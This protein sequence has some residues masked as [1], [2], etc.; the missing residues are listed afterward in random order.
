MSTFPRRRAH[1]RVIKV[2]CV[3]FYKANGIWKSKKSLRGGETVQQWQCRTGVWTPC[4][5]V[6]SQQRSYWLQRGRRQE[7]DSGL[8]VCSLAKKMQLQTQRL[9]T[10]KKGWKMTGEFTTGLLWLPCT[11]SCS[12]TQILKKKKHKKERTIHVWYIVSN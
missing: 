8:L 2:M 6:V 7:D 1:K 11:H 12:H 3:L 9:Q 5:E 10:L 4:E